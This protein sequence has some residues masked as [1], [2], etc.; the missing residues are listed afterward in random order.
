[1]TAERGKDYGSNWHTFQKSRILE[2]RV[3][4]LLFGS[5]NRKQEQQSQLLSPKC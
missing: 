1:M 5:H 4:E 3:D 2:K